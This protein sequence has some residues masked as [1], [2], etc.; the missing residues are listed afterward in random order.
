MKWWLVKKSFK[1]FFT[2]PGWLRGAVVVLF[3]LVLI[4]LPVLGLVVGLLVLVLG[5][6]SLIVAPFKKIGGSKHVPWA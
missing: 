6:V 2:M 4:L 5:L 3:G 1:W